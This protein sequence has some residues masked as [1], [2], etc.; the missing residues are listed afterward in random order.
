MRGPDDSARG[1]LVAIATADVYVEY[2]GGRLVAGVSVSAILRAALHVAE[3]DGAALPS[4]HALARSE[5]S[6]DYA[7]AAE[8]PADVPSDGAFHALA[9]AGYE[10]KSSVRYVVVPREGQQVFR[11]LDLESPL[12]GALLA[13]PLDVY[14]SE[15]DGAEIAYRTTTRMPQ[16]PP[17]GRVEIGLGT[18]P[19][20]KVARTTSFQEETAGLLGGSLALGHSIGVELRNLLPREVT[21][22]VRERVPVVRKDDAEVKVEVGQVDPPWERW[23]QEQTLRGGYLWKVK[24][25]PGKSRNLSAKY[26]IKISSKLEL[27]GGNRRES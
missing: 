20:I 22:E 23:D 18:E 4:G 5:D 24:L 6:Y 2:L 9:V 12:D 10:T 25:E 1:E 17:R 13:G 27:A 8:L 21:V 3:I 7:Y 19:A 15:K 16:T 26:T 11:L 14:E